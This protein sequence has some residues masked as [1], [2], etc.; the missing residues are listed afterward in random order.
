MLPQSLVIS[1]YPSPKSMQARLPSSQLPICSLHKDRDFPATTTLSVHLCTR[2]NRPAVDYGS[3][4]RSCSL[5]LSLS[6][7]GSHLLATVLCKLGWLVSKPRDLLSVSA[8][9]RP[10]D[11]HT[12][13]PLGL[14]LLNVVLDIGLRSSRTL[15]TELSLAAERSML[16]KVIFI[17][18]L[19]FQCP[20][21]SSY[22][23][24][25]HPSTDVSASRRFTT[26]IL[27]S[28]PTPHSNIRRFLP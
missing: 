24:S 12:S 25:I 19:C 13:P 28:P 22:V 8:S 27:S 7:W 6:L 16:E 4:L 17:L 2:T 23:S 18:L 5:A 14:S 3:L 11:K 9:P 1:T 10:D 21:R 15:L 26:L 20:L